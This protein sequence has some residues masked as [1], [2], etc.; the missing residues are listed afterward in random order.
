MIGVSVGLIVSRNISK[1]IKQNDTTEEKRKT[2]HHIKKNRKYQV[3][4]YAYHWQIKAK[5]NLTNN[6][7]G[8]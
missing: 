3:N 6:R 2:N 1:V 8:K 4:T 7:L 5:S